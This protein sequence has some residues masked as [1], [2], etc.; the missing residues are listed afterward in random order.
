MSDL[1]EQE[2]SWSDGV[3]EWSERASLHI[4]DCGILISDSFF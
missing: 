4:L 1:G 3:L 2:K